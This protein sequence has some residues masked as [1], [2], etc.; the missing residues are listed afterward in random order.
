MKISLSWD[1]SDPE[2]NEVSDSY[3]E[4]SVSK[5]DSEK[6]QDGDN[7]KILVK[8]GYVWS[9]KPKV[10]RKT[11]MR[12]TV[13]EKPGAKENGCQAD[14]PLKLFDLFF[15][16]AMITEMVTWTNQK[17]ENVKTSYTSKPGFVCNISVTEICALIGILLFLGATKSSKKSTASIWAKGGTL[18]ANLH[19][20]DE[21]EAFFVSCLLLML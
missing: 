10:V 6:K 13:K 18:Q 17:I 11:P 3:S 9:Q 20:S 14:T 16:G 1:E 19:S 4:I 8:D 2:S 5:S 7:R 15:D 21:S 12:N